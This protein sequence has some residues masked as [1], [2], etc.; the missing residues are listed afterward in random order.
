ML[1]VAAP[2]TVAVA[3]GTLGIDVGSLFDFT[4]FA[5]I[6]RS[7]FKW[8]ISCPNSQNLRGMIY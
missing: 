6:L 7:H 4:S 5:K 2:G 8:A 3:L 1:L